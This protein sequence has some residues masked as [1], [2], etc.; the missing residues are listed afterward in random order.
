MIDAQGTITAVNGDT[1]EV[2][3]DETWG[4][5]AVTRRRSRASQHRQDAVRFAAHFPGVELEIQR[6]RPG[7]GG[8]CRP[9]LCGAAPCLLTSF[10]CWRCWSV[11]SADRRWPES[12]GRSL[13]RSVVCL[14]CPAD[15]SARVQARSTPE[16]EFPAV[17]PLLNFLRSSRSHRLINRWLT[18][19][20]IDRH[21]A[22]CYRVFL[23]IVFADGPSSG[24][25][26]A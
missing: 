7:D 4:A 6:L 2:L 23:R 24:Q 16:L 26:L 21:E 17:Y 1:A 9:G 10:R 13:A 22:N 25:R 11:R 18:H 3:M 12:S 14:A 15:P 19:G 5:A 8:H 20:G